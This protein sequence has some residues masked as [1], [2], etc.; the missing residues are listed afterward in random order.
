[1]RRHISFLYNRGDEQ[2][3]I[4]K[5]AGYDIGYDA[6]Y[7]S[8]HKDGISDTKAQYA[9]S[10]TRGVTVY[11]TVSGSKYHKKG[12]SYL[13]KSAIPVSIIEAKEEGYTAC[14]RCHPPS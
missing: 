13:S 14:S 5:T 12:C 6:G 3:K 11:I 10:P 7:E 9:K 1:M 2:Y 4:G 8:G